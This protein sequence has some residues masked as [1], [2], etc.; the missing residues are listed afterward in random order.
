K[1][2][3]AAPA[4]SDTT[5]VAV[6]S[7]LSPLGVRLTAHRRAVLGALEASDRPL[8]AEEVVQASG[9]PVSTAYRNLAEL[10]DA[11]V[12]ARVTGAGGGD[13]HELAEP[14]SQHHH[15]HLVCVECGIVTD[16]E[17]SPQL[18]RLIEREVNA[19]LEHSG[20][21]V[22]HHLFDV[23]GRCRQCVRG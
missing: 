17:P 2:P 4:L 6:Q 19:L 21:E 22:S 9:V 16:F 23:R 14:F 8:T 18:E 1:S 10:V 20:F 13:R 5:A 11:G 15:H 7:L 12:V 3:S